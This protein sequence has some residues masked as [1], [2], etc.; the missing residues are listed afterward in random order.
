MKNIVKKNKLLIIYLFSIFLISLIF[1]ILEYIGV[2]YNLLKTLT[3]IINLI[4]VSLYAFKN[5]SSSNLSGYKSGFRS[6]VKM[7]F[8]LLFINVI[9]LNSFTFKTLI[10]YLIIMITCIIS[11]IICK[12][13]QKNYS[14]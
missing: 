6:G 2:S 12:N 5:S 13:K 8:T 4:I 11:A 1:S 3:I 14:S 10:Y 9:T 7:C